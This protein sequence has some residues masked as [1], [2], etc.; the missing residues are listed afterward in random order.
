MD[1]EPILTVNVRCSE[2]VS[3]AGH[4]KTVVMIPFT[5]TAEGKLF[6]GSITGTGTDTQ[7]IS[8]DGVC[9]L[10]ARYMLKGRDF[11]GTPC[12]LFIENASD[13]NGV[14]RPMIVTDSDALAEWETAKL[15]SGI[16][17]VEGRVTVRIYK[18]DE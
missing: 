8:A 17:S 14:L 3:V 18:E 11:T 12:T 10:S 4:T 16:E 5:G 15:R 1:K 7:K 13:E 9:R 6:S 2:P